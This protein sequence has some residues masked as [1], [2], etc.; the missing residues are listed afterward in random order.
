M[1][2]KFHVI[3]YLFF[4]IFAA[5]T[6]W[7]LFYIF[8]KIHIEPLKF[9]YKI[10]II[11]DT[12]FFFGLILIPLFWALIYYVTGDYKNIYRKSRLKE[13][14]GT[15]S[16][17]TVGV[18]IIFFA[19]ILDDAI[20]TYKDYYTS[21]LVLFIL[22]FTLTYIPRLT[23]T[24]FTINRIRKRKIGFNTIIIGGN[25]KAN[26]LYIDLVSQPKSAGN[27]FI[28][29][30]NVHNNSK[31][32][33]SKHLVH[34]GNL[35]DLKKQISEKNIEEIIIAIESSE[36]EETGKI[37]NMLEGTKVI[38]KAIPD[39]YDILTGTVKMSS[40]YSP[41]L[42]QI[43]HELMPAWEENLKRILD[44]FISLL[45]IVFSIPTSFFIIAGIKFT[46][47]GPIIYSHE[48]VG[49][50]GKPFTIYKFRSMCVDAEKNGPALSSKNDNRITPF[51]RFIRKTRLDELP[52]FINVI[53]GDMSVVGPRPE[54]QFYIDKITQKAPHYSHLLKVRPGITSW[55]QVRF[56]YAEN[57][58]EMI[59]RL[60]YDIIYIENMSL[61]VD[62][63]IMI[64]TIKTVFEGKGK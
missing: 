44:V 15:L 48:R 25:E 54:R 60:K 30:V 59:E 61:Y 7:S 17:T 22:H 56:G 42:I 33:L 11:F 12:K 63:K 45:A 13:F 40:I 14:G 53:I 8:R 36:R 4:D 23:I 28:G 57:I 18:I 41:A 58:D 19:L 64:Y 37:L 3:K 21:F 43:T 27:K 39:M 62:I 24:S 46:S 52:Q 10:P 32:K 35:Q 38:I 29:F 49:R 51:G 6:A 26:N 5:A 55:G 16:L 34:L 20:A 31:Y 50:Y 9:G 1:N 2:K 47:K